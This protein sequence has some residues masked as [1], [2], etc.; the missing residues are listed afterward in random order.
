M[1]RNRL[2]LLIGGWHVCTGRKELV[3]AILESSNYSLDQQHVGTFERGLG[4][5]LTFLS[6]P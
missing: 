6:D 5:V 1:P 2:H 4:T 3:V